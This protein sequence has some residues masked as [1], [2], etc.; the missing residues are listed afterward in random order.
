[1]QSLYRRHEAQCRY[2]KM[3]V[4]H[5]KCNCPVWM[6]GYDEHGNRGR[7][8][9]KTRSWTHAQ[10]RLSKLEAGG[11]LPARP[12][13]PLVAKAVQSFLTDCAT[14]NIAPSTLIRYTNTLVPLGEFFTG[15][16]ADLD[17]ETLRA[18]RAARG[19]IAPASA[20]VEMTT[21]KSFLRF[22]LNSKWTTEDFSRKGVLRSARIDSVPT[23]P[24][25]AEEV[26]RI[27]DACNVIRNPHNPNTN[28][29]IQARA[30]GLILVM[31]YSGFRISDAVQLRR[32]SVNFDSGQMLIRVMKTRV[33]LYSKLPLVALE[34]L[35][36]IPVESPYFFW[37][38]V[39]QPICAFASARRTIATL[40]ELANITDGH[41][42]RFRDT[43]AVELL[44]NGAD[45]RTVQ[46]LLGHTSIKTTEKHYAPYVLGMQRILD[47]A[48]STLHF[49]SHTH[50]AMNAQQNTL[51]DS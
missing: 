48:V 31:L 37:S 30:R 41:P 10:E 42:H 45:L 20:A 28:E 27:L 12:Y 11:S 14:R 17:L 2:K 33:P 51:G 3:G 1:M 43:F 44:L 50:G 24:F 9:L 29:R 32:D 13:S 39:S 7:R 18:F 35:R 21:L 40:L 23:M 16:I 46:L 22:C 26:T 47:E 38:G 19:V 25:N 5:I 4:R 15:T 49:G 36:A 8:S 6:D 34:A